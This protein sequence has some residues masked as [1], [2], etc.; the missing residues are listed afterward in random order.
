MR[1]PGRDAQGREIYHVY[2][3]EQRQDMIEAARLVGV[4]FS[5]QMCYNHE[6][7]PVKVCTPWSAA[8]NL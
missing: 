3:N 5:V 1:R 8:V 6:R 4:D 2:E 7:R